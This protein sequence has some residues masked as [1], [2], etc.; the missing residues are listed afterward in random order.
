M[1]QDINLLGAAQS[2]SRQLPTALH[3]AVLAAAILT[4][5]IAASYRMDGQVAAEDARLTDANAA[6]DELV[7]S[8]EERSQ[9]LAQRNTDA[10]LLSGLLSLER[11]AADKARVLDLLSGETLGNTDGFSEHLAALG[12]RHPPGLWLDDVRIGEGGRQVL[13]RGNALRAEL[14]PRFIEG[15]QMEPAFEGTAFQS[16]ELAG[17]PVRFALATGCEDGEEGARLACFEEAGLAE[18]GPNPQQGEAHDE[19]AAAP[20]EKAPTAT[21]EADAP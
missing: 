1:S 13:L 17:A 20:M 4:A 12:R 21:K 9:F 2:A 6:I 11:E 3:A 7:F 16:F 18:P 8:L 10:A 5:G 15:L 14:I 19:S